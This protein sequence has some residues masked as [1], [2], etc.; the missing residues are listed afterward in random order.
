MGIPPV[1]VMMIHE[2]LSGDDVNAISIDM[3][4]DYT[5]E[6]ANTAAQQMFTQ[7]YEKA[8]ALAKD[9]SLPVDVQDVYMAHAKYYRI[10][11]LYKLQRTL[12]NQTAEPNP[13]DNPAPAEE[14]PVEGD[15]NE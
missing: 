3:S 4:R 5:G 14:P 9:D 6:A 15:N 2:I 13:A 10:E 11:C 7:L 1:S 8:A 12:V